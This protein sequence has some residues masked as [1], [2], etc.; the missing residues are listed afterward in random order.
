MSYSKRED[1]VKKQTYL[2][3][4]VIVTIAVADIEWK[5]LYWKT[6]VSHIDERLRGVRSVAW[7]R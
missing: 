2:T 7:L 3:F 6:I 5:H 1:F 4:R